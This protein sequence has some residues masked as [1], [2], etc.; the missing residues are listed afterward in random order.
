M[1]INPFDNFSDIVGGTGEFLGFALASILLFLAI[2]GLIILIIVILTVIINWKLL[3]KMGNEGWK[4]LI[5][6]YNTW[7]LCEGVGIFPHWSW[8]IVVASSAFAGA[9]GLGAIIASVV[10]VYFGV[11]YNIA[12]AR[13]FGKEDSYAILLFFF[14]PIVGFF[15]LKNDYL[16]AKG[17]HDIVMDD[18][19]KFHKN[20]SNEAK[21]VSEN[22]TEDKTK[23]DS[24]FCSSCG[25]ELKED[26]KFCS[27]CGKEL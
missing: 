16:G 9:P 25:H 7:S 10:A 17:C 18:W 11:I 21:V 12:L 23:K 24:K 19:F 8:I 3:T 1:Y 2:L 27:S 14:F 4:A 5:P 22:K 15:L 20:D 6:V 13:S 26:D